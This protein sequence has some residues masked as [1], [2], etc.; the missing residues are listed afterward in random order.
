MSSA[1]SK[2]LKDYSFYKIQK[3]KSSQYVIKNETTKKMYIK[4]KSDFVEEV[5]LI[6]VGYLENELSIAQELSSLGVEISGKKEINKQ[7]YDYIL[8]NN[9]LTLIQDVI[10]YPKCETIIKKPEGIYLNTYLPTKYLDESFNNGC[11]K[12][13]SFP[14]IKK[15]IMNLCNDDV[16]AYEYNLKVLSHSIC[17]PHI[18]RHGYLVYQGAGAS[19]KGTL[20]ELVMEPI[21]EDY[22]LVGTLKDLVGDFNGHTQNKLWVIVEEKDDDKNKNE[23][24]GSTLKYISGNS[25]RVFETKGVDREQKESF[26]NFAMTTNETNPQLELKGHDRRASVL[27]YSRA[28]GGSNEKAPSV[29]LELVKHIPNE[30]DNFVSYLKNLKFDIEDIFMPLETE[31]RNKIIKLDMNNVDLFIDDIKI[32]YEDSLFNFLLEDF[33]LNFQ[34]DLT[35]ITHQ[36]KEDKEKQT[37]L[38][39]SDVYKFFL[40]YC[41][42]NEKKATSENRFFPEFYNNTNIESYLIKRDNRRK[43]YIYFTEFL[44]YFKMKA[45]TFT[46]DIETINLGEKPNE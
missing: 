35:I 36:R 44:K 33:N 40:K 11:I 9:G 14:Y 45:E 39:C 38:L 21:F 19:G 42:I 23:N 22:L 8:E 31:A 27:G 7:L 12:N 26:T 3:S 20:F 18:T 30:L 5:Y 24:I 6:A 28:L 4:S 10:F 17:K 1:I 29:R 41:A 43:K 13:N 25:K 32:K 15:L 34:D 2:L 16:K 46:T 37:Y